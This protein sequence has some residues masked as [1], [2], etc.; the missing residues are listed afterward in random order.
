MEGVGTEA[1]KVCQPVLHVSLA[2]A[3]AGHARMACP[4]SK[5]TASSASVAARWAAS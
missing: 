1:P 2:S 3:E 4:A 5:G